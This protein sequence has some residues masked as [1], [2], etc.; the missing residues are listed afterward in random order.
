LGLA[1]SLYSVP[2][3]AVGKYEMAREMLDEGLALLRETGDAYRIA[4]ALNYCGDLARCEEDWERAQ[5]AYE[6][7]ISL[8]REIDAVRD[9]ASLLHNLG[10]TCLHLGDV[11]G[12]QDLFN[13]SMA[14]H[15][16]Q[17]NRP[18]MAECLIG[19]AGLVIVSDLPAVGARLLAA[20]AA[21]GGRQVTSRWAA[22][23][24]A[25]EHYQARAGAGLTERR[26]QAELAAGRALSLEQAVAYAQDVARRSAVAQKARRKLDALTPREREVAALIAQ[27]RPNGEIAEELVVSKRTIEKHISN[28][29]SK[30]GFTQRAQIVRWAIESGLV[31]GSE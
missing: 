1:L 5:K 10:H 2:A 24:L 22:T 6:E 21:L 23:R 8:L 25:Y 26:F 30:L 9:L 19:F 17:G 12:A 7:G 4:M 11:A 28:I 31:N 3:M 13:A 29:R 20:A 15:Q 18:G 27:A 14:S 16:K